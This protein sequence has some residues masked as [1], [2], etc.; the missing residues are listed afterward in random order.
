MFHT[1]KDTAMSCPYWVC[2]GCPLNGGC[3]LARSRELIEL[4]RKLRDKAANI[5]QAGI[6]LRNAKPKR[7]P[8]SVA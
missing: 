3:I 5:Q 8:A 7:R 1:G 2:N 6:L 4:S